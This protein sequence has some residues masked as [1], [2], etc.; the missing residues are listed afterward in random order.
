MEQFFAALRA[1]SER[2]ASPE[3]DL[4]LLMLVDVGPYD[5]DEDTESNLST[6]EQRVKVLI[7]EMRLSERFLI[8]ALIRDIEDTLAAWVAD[9]EQG[10]RA[11]GVLRVREAKRRA[12]ERATPQE[13][14]SP[15]SQ[16]YLQL[17]EKFERS[18]Y[19]TP[20]RVAQRKREL[21]AWRDLTQPLLELDNTESGNTAE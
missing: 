12:L 11:R 19:P 1:W 21:A 2:T 9:A 14:Q 18:I 8:V 3:D 4:R 17:F 15:A 13:R 7:G 10:D 16:R 5:A 20:E 6:I